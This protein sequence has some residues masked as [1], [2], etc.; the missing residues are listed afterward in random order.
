MAGIRESVATETLLYAV[1][2]GML[3]EVCQDDLK[4]VG[5]VKN[6][7]RETGVISGRVGFLG[8]TMIVLRISKK[9]NSTELRIQ[10]NGPVAGLVGIEVG[11]V[12]G[13]INLDSSGVEAPVRRPR[14]EECYQQ[15]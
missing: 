9:D 8:S 13:V 11:V 5:K 15:A 12:S 3:A 4:S 1:D 7:S 6:V 2:S 10:A 14:H